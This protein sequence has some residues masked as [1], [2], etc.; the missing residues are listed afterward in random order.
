MPE[1][2]IRPAVASDIPIL[3]ALDHNYQSEYA[4]QM[5]I[6]ND[7]EINQVNVNFRQIRLPRSVQI[8]YP[9]DPKKMVDD[10][11]QRSGLLVASHK[12]QVIGYA[13]LM[14]DTTTSTTW[15]TDLVVDRP[16]RRHGIGSAL[17][18]AALEWAT[19]MGSQ[20]LIF[21]LQTKNYPALQ[22]AQK[23]GFDFCGFNDRHLPDHE[24]GLFFVKKLR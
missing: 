7:R 3:M 18:L 24:I 4:W 13:S 12:G 14:I 9:H 21:T 10:W 5:K 23:L 17:L 16:L 1:I 20:N 6:D 15:V 22:M 8:K 11:T 2:H 19:Q